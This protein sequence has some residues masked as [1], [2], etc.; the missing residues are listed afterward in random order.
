MC[1]RSPALIQPSGLLPRT[2][3]CREEQDCSESL[4]MSAPELN[5]NL[6]FR[7]PRH[8]PLVRKL[9]LRWVGVK[10]GMNFLSKEESSLPSLLKPVLVGK[11]T[12][13]SLWFGYR[14]EKKSTQ[15]ADVKS[16]LLQEKLCRLFTVGCLYG[17]VTWFEQPTPG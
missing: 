8:L 9:G 12:S 14:E 5:R 3:R 4:I 17:T 6:G 13:F 2:Q 7:A 11:L 16:L 1:S 10:R 15:F